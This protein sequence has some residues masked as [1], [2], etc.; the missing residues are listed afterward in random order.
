ML[1]VPVSK[2]I[3]PPLV[4][5]LPPVPPARLPTMT[6]PALI[7]TL[8]PLTSIWLAEPGGVPPDIVPTVML[9]VLAPPAAPAMVSVPVLTPLA[10]CMMPRLRILPMTMLLALMMLVALPRFSVL[11]FE[12]ALGMGVA[13]SKPG[14]MVPSAM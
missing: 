5:L 7:L 14:V 8:C 11:G 12:G 1:K 4:V 2:M 6:V 3:A 10:H 9:A 13:G